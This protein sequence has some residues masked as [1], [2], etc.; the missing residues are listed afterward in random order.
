MPVAG[1]QAATLR[2]YLA[3]DFERHQRLFT[4]LDRTAINQ[5]Y[6][7]ASSAT[8]RERQLSGCACL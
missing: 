7:F 3:G 1:E 5:G 8:M 4:Q 6:F 2:A